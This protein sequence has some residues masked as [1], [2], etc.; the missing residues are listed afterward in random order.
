MDLMNQ[1]FHSKV[2]FPAEMKI[3]GH[4]NICTMMFTAALFVTARNLK[5]SNVYQKDE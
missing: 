5:N 2:F 4:T 1:Q 3:Y